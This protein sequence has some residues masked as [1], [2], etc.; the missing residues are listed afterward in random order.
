MIRNLPSDAQ[1]LLNQLNAGDV[2]H[3]I[4]SD[5]SVLRFEGFSDLCWQAHVDRFGEDGAYAGVAIVE[6]EIHQQWLS[7]HL[8]RQITS[9]GWEGGSQPWDD[10]FHW[11]WLTD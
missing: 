10:C 8:G 2:G 3:E 5:G 7:A 1:L 4:L 11:A 9:S 6:A